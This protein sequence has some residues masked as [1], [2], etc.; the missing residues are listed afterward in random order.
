MTYRFGE[1]GGSFT[2]PKGLLT[3]PLYPNNYPDNA[4]CVYTISMSTGIY[5]V[6]TFQSMDIYK[7]VDDDCSTDYL[8]IGDGST[9]GSTVLTKLCGKDIPVPIKSSQSQ[10]WIK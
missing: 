9:V 6:L 8:E 4:D 5:I 2:T 3:S 1:C 7:D 10:L